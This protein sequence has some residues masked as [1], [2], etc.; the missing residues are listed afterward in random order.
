MRGFIRDG[1]ILFV[2]FCDTTRKFP[3][4]GQKIVVEPAPVVGVGMVALLLAEGDV[5]V[6]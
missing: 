6:Q 2:N 5:G 4:G 3:E 1:I